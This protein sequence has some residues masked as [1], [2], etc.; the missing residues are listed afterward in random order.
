[1][2]Y[3]QQDR[4][5]N[6]TEHSELEKN[7]ERVLEQTSE[8]TRANYLKRFKSLC[9]RIDKSALSTGVSKRQAFD[10]EIQSIEDK[11]SSGM[12]KQSSVRQYKASILYGL[13]CAYE[14][15]K[16]S[17]A[18]DDGNKDKDRVHLL[19]EDKELILGLTNELSPNDLSELYD[20]VSAWQSE[21]AATAK[22]L[23]NKAHL[24]SNT[25]SRKAKLFDEGLYDYIMSHDDERTLLLRMFIKLN[26]KLGLRPNEWYSARLVNKEYFDLLVDGAV[27]PKLA[28]TYG[29]NSKTTD[30]DRVLIQQSRYFLAPMYPDIKHEYIGHE[31][32]PVLV[33]K[34]SKNTHG[35]ANGSYRYILLDAL[36]DEDMQQ[37]PDL[38]TKLHQKHAETVPDFQDRS[39]S[40]FDK[41]VA[42]SLQNQFKYWLDSDPKC[43]EILQSSYEKKLKNYT[44]EKSR[45][46]KS[47]KSWSR[48]EPIKEYPTLYSTRHQAVS[49]AKAAGMSPVVM[50]AL[51]GHASV[52]TADRHYGR[53]TDSWGSGMVTPHQESIN[54]VIVGLT[55]PQ[56]ELALTQTHP[57]ELVSAYSEFISSIDEPTAGQVRSLNTAE[58]QL[59]QGN[60]HE[61][62]AAIASSDTN[63]HDRLIKPLG[64]MSK[65]SAD[66]GSKGALRNKTRKAKFK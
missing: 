15:S 18:E 55:E 12:L 57:H 36:S 52:V 1:M 58:S 45:A 37:L 28:P 23:D 31:D 20:K 6:V 30:Y 54:R 49:D 24:E 64:N 38:I 10:V 19:P 47:G 9:K 50:A 7:H 25:S 3:Q 44:Y 43:Q 59:S 14:L 16:A 63:I 65:A 21:D 61:A 29:L 27:S 22:L 32:R 40:S 60:T 51:F 11:R 2:I 56:I 46:L 5:F 53:I 41:A 26:I 39:A 66:S 8:K 35:R 34:N 62:I 17:S 42:Q 33:I 4:E 13:T 48:Q